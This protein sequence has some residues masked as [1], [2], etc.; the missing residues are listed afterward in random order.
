[1]ENKE[2]T[3]PV[4][5]KRL[6]KYVIFS[7][8]ALLSTLAVL[9]YLYWEQSKVFSFLMDNHPSELYLAQTAPVGEGIVVLLLIA[10][11][12]S[13]AAAVVTRRHI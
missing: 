3:A 10:A 8:A 13:A 5:S 4:Q 9:G 12:T 6:G 11:L 2:A 1:M 7:Y